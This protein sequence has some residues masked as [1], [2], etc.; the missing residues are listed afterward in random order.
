MYYNKIKPRAVEHYT[1]LRKVVAGVTAEGSHNTPHAAGNYEPDVTEFW[2]TYQALRKSDPRWARI[3]T[4]SLLLY[5][6]TQ[7]LIASPRMNGHACFNLLSVTGK[8]M[9]FDNIDITMPMIMPDGGMMSFNVRNCERRSLEQIQEAVDDLRRRLENTNLNRVMIGPATEDTLRKLLR[10]R[11]DMVLL[12][13]LGNVI[14]P[15]RLKFKEFN[16]GMDRDIP[17]K[18][19]LSREDIE[20]GTI[21]VTNVGSVY[22]GSYAPLTM[23]NLLPPQISSVGIGAMVER[24][25]VITHTDGSKEI[26]LRKYIPFLILF[27]HRALDYG[28]IV[29]FMKRLDEI[30]ANPEEMKGWIA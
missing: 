11:L 16:E 9:F 27:D 7:G 6:I 28:D 12:R 10:G 15:G 22:K 25:G 3:T 21:A 29:P 5:V 1:M 2:D 30:F 26:A 23:A 18:D 14:G 13:S 24:P 19:R 17:A 4:N 8:T 20:P